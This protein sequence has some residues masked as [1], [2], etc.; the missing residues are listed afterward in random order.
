MSTINKMSDSEYRAYPAINYSNLKHARKSLL[1]YRSAVEAGPDP[2]LS[3]KLAVFSAV[4]AMVL[5]PYS[6]NEQFAVYDGRR[7]ARTKAYKEFLVEHAG[8]LILTPSEL[9]QVN[10]MAEAVLSHPWVGE[11]LAHEGTR[12]EAMSIWEDPDAGT[13]KAKMDIMHY[14]PENGLLIADL[15][16]FGGTDPSFISREGARRAWP[17]QH[18]HYL[19]GAAALLGLSNEEQAAL[20]TTAFNIV[21]EAA[22]PH[23]VV[24][25]QW[26]AETMNAAF[27]E[28]R[29]LLMQVSE[30]QSTGVWPGRHTD[31]WSPVVITPP[32]YLL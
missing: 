1:H 26:S 17:L 11:L 5:E 25:V 14:S 13:C 8:K 12:C 19:H 20:S 10:T 23:D 15:K 9:E 7:D 21:V 22:A 32:P 24:V 4:H 2:A 18:A 16:C 28:H 6:F 29:S 31:P 3:Q 27:A 30:A